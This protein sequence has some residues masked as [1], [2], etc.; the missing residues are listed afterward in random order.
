[1]ARFDPGYTV[2]DLVFYSGL[3]GGIAVSYL[4]MQAMDI[5]MWQIFKLLISLGVGVVIGGGCLLA[6]EQ[7]KR[8]KWPA[9]KSDLYDDDDSLDNSRK[10][11]DDRRY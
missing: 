4:V 11:D 1:M 6:F 3:I 2:S 5:E 9:D 10:Y 8:P 7:F